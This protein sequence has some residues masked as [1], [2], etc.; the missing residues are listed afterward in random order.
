MTA[1]QNRLGRNP[2]S[3][4]HRQTE[5]DLSREYRRLQRNLTEMYQRVFPDRLAQRTVVVIPSLTLD[6]AELAKIDGAHHY[7]ER[8]LFLLMLLRL[9]RTR[10]IYVTS[11]S[12]SS[13]VI[14]Y[15]LHLLPGIPSTH[16]RRRLTLLDCCDASELPLVQKILDRPRLIRKIRAAIPDCRTAHM[17][18]FNSTPL[19]KELAVRLGIPLYA[20][21]P[22]LS[23]LGSKSGSRSMLKAAGL[24]V[25]DG[26][27]DLGSVDEMV[28]A[29]A[30]LK[31]RNPGLR[32]G[33]VKLNEGFSGEGNATFSFDGCPDTD[34]RS[35]IREKLP[36]RLE[37]A[38]VGETWSRFAEKFADMEGIVEEFVE[39]EGK[40]SPSV[41]CRVNPLGGVE[42]ISTHD[43]ILGGP[44]GQIFLGCTFPADEE[45]RLDLQQAGAA[46]GEVLRD[47]GVLGRFGVDFISVRDDTGW[48]HY[49]IEINLRKG[50]TT[51]PFM[52][53]QFLTNGR[54][55]NES[56]EFV[57]PGGQSRCYMASDNVCSES[58]R[59][60]C[61]DDL[62]DIAVE[63]NVHFHS[64]IQ[65]GVVFHLIGA[66]SE[67]G[68]LGV[69]CIGDTPTTARSYYQ[70]TLA[71]LNTSF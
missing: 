58:F 40:V 41:Q 16:A 7:E 67:F 22:D 31:K 27:E 38:A 18:C 1:T 23:H 65:Q 66:L 13:T 12:I 52:M 20:N 45:Y 5:D 3:G 61:P 35:W 47:Q 11:Q 10:L 59:G 46:V 37:F 70:Q 68:K 34:F 28:E 69:L 48:K 44:S 21:D 8:M 32:R 49:A 54:Y 43:Q 14:D 57:V 36:R 30:R 60:L 25:P 63:N 50:G 39:G 51:H 55:C 2:W 19:E 64:T 26:S 17:S 33:V 9:P 29:L 15:F 62:M 53:L 42:V 4:V 6:P 56:G 24:L 71:A